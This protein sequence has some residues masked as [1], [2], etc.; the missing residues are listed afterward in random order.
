MSDNAVQQILQAAAL[1]CQQQ[2]L[3]FTTMRNNIL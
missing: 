2:G 1:Q 3:R